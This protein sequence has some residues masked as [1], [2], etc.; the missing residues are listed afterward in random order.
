MSAILGSRPGALWSKLKGLSPVH[1]RELIVL[2]VLT[3]VMLVSGAAVF[4]MLGEVWGP[5]NKPYGITHHLFYSASLVLGLDPRSILVF[6]SFIFIGLFVLIAF[7]EYKQMNGILLLGVTG[8]GAAILLRRGIF[9]NNLNLAS[10]P[11][12]ILGG[13]LTGIVLGGLKRDSNGFYHDFTRGDDNSSVREF[14]RAMP[15]VFLVVSAIVLLGLVERLFQYDS[16]IV[17]DNTQVVFQDFQLLAVQLGETFPYIIASGV[18]LG[19]IYEFRSNVHNK[20]II[21][22][23]GTGSGKSTTMAGL[24]YSID[25]YMGGGRRAAKP[26]GPLEI[27]SSRLNDEDLEAFPSTPEAQVLPLE[28]SY[29]HGL[30]FPRKVT[31]RTLD[32]A[33]DHMQG[34]RPHESSEDVATDDIDEVFEV[35]KHMLEN[36]TPDGTADEDEIDNAWFDI[37]WFGDTMDVGKKPTK[38]DAFSSDDGHPEIVSTL[39]KDLIWHADSIGML[40]PLEDYAYMTF[41]RGTSPPYIEA[42]HEEKEVKTFTRPR[43]IDGYKRSYSKIE[44]STNR[45]DIFYVA[46]FSDLAIRDFEYMSKWADMG[47]NHLDRWD[48]FA[49]HIKKEFLNSEKSR[50]ESHLPDGSHDL[51][52]IYYPIENTEPVDIGDADDFEIDLDASDSRLPLHGGRELLDRMGKR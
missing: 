24:D 36:A 40:Y 18:F 42:N 8:I 41:E 4:Q 10:S 30:L 32:Y 35:G 31:I 22:L 21:L 43:D 7:D 34:L 29:K 27:L 6:A 2:F 48:L 14:D 25:Q 16:P 47:V 38:L 1:K 44:K 37:D 51:V 49:Q 20:E 15:R 5:A 13:F 23:G 17:F 33:G 28:F 11:L 50:A 12:L 9:I 45:S 39:I 46:T 52:P 26:N 3:P 19:S